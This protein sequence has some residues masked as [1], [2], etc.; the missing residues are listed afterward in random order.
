MNNMRKEIL[1]IVILVLSGISYKFLILPFSSPVVDIL[2]AIVLLLLLLSSA[3]R[4]R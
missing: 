2:T 3:G 4:N 1:I